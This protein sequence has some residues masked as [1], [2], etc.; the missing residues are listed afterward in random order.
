MIERLRA[1]TER[2]LAEGRLVVR[3]IEDAKE[4]L[5]GLAR[6]GTSKPAQHCASERVSSHEAFETLEPDDGKLSRPVL[7]H[8][9]PRNENFVLVGFVKQRP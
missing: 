9:A 4:K 2:L 3:E 5:D 8:Y 1:E 6:K 7:S